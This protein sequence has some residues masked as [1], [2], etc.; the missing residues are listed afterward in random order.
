[1]QNGA[2]EENIVEA[3]EQLSHRSVSGSITS[4]RGAGNGRNTTK[5]D[6]DGEA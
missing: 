4:H 2:R 6:G 3:E 5:G 1:M